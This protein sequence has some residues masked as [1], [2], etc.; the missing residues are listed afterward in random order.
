MPS[1]L[2]TAA[3]DAIT[4]DGNNADDHAARELQLWIDNTESLLSPVPGDRSQL[5]PQD[6]EEHLRPGIGPQ[7]LVAPG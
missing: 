3:L 5:S 2:S 4:N 1:T 6:G 7:G